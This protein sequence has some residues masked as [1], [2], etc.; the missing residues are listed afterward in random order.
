MAA[1]DLHLKPRANMAKGI[2]RSP[3]IKILDLSVTPKVF[4][5]RLILINWARENPGTNER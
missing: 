5:Q 4:A 2:L 1:R 3:I